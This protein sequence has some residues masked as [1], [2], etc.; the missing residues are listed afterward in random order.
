MNL[1]IV[2]AEKLLDSESNNGTF[3]NL[4]KIQQ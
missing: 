2:K 1:N 4:L 3:S